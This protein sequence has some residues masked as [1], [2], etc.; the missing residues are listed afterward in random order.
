MTPPPPSVDQLTRALSAVG[1][2]IDGIRADQWSAPTPCTDW[3]VHDLVNHLVGMNLV[4]VAMLSN[5]ALPERGTDRLGDDPAGAYRASGAAVQT[6]FEQPG[7]LERTYQGPLGDATG[8]QRLH[9]RITDLLAHGW[10]LAVATGQSAELPE[11]LAEQALAFSRAQLATMS[12]TGRFGP[13]QT[14]DDDAPAIDQLVAF[15]GR[16]ISA[17]R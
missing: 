15:L 7:V 1:Q 17:R 10:D 9:I 16:P 6:A 12:R 13:E 8:A 11:D 14:V 5:Q 3:T 4:F 2:L